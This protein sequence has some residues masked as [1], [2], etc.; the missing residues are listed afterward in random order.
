[1]EVLINRQN[2]LQ[3]QGDLQVDPHEKQLDKSGG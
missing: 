1:V 3:R 2:P